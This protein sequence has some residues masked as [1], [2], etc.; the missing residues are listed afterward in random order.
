M[1]VQSFPDMIF[2]LKKSLNGNLREGCSANRRHLYSCYFSFIKENTIALK[3][4]LR[5]HF[6]VLMALQDFLRI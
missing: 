1:S 2:T 3:F 4:S 5:L 6:S